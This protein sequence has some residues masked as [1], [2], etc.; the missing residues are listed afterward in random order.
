M[1]GTTDDAPH[2]DRAERVRRIT[3]AVDDLRDDLIAF[4]QELVRIPSLTGDEGAVQK[5]VASRMRSDGLAV[6]V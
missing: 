4:L 3:A 6:D 5:V 1:I 2:R